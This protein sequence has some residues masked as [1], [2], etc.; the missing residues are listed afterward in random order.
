V[1]CLIPGAFSLGCYSAASSAREHQHEDEA[2]GDNCGLQI[3]LSAKSAAALRNSSKVLIRLSGRAV[4]RSI[5]LNGDAVGRQ[6]DAK[7]Q[8]MFLEADPAAG[9]VSRGR[10]Y[11]AKIY[12]LACCARAPSGQAAAAPPNRVMNSRR[13]IQ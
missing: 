1:S 10:N 8:A 6:P 9:R 11:E 4:R 5:A 12:S 7:P 2:G 3:Q 13:L